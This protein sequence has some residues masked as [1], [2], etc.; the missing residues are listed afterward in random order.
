MQQCRLF[1]A[2]TILNVTLAVL[3]VIFTK[4][5]DAAGVLCPASLI[6]FVV[7]VFETICYINILID[8]WLYFPHTMPRHYKRKM[9]LGI[10][11]VKCR[12]WICYIWH[13]GQWYEQKQ[14]ALL[15]GINRSTLMNH[16]KNN[17][18]GKVGR[19]TIL[20]PDEEK[21]IVHALKKLGDVSGWD[22]RVSH[23]YHSHQWVRQWC[24]SH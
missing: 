9:M 23:Q 12:Q 1:Y 22:Q 17:R 24:H 6:L 14:S 18:C 15:H 2:H 4:A 3:L 11:D 20:T 7:F 10:M 19:P 5:K 16:L 13:Q 21:L 8:L